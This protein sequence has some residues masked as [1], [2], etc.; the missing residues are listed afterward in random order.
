MLKLR[1]SIPERTFVIALSLPSAV[2]VAGSKFGC[3]H[4]VMFKW[5]WFNE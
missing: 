3:S 2:Q 1:F 4:L 5:F